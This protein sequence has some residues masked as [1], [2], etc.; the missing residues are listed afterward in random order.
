MTR[1]LLLLST[2]MMT[3]FQIKNKFL[4]L[5]LIYFIHLMP[6]NT[7]GCYNSSKEMYRCLHLFLERDFY[8][9]QD[10]FNFEPRDFRQIPFRLDQ[11]ELQQLCE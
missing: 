2:K 6:S 11:M 8:L 9:V 1:S 5:P 10:L 3:S 4:I 7:N